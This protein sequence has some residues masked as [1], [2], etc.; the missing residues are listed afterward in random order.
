MKEDIQ[1]PKCGQTV[2]VDIPDGQA[3]V[4]KCPNCSSTMMISDDHASD[5]QNIQ[6]QINF[7]RRTPQQ[8]AKLP[9]TPP[10]RFDEAISLAS[11]RLT[12]T[13]GRSRRSEFWWWLLASAIATG[14]LLLIPH[15]GNLAFIV[16]FI[17]IYGVTIRRLNDVFAP[18]WIGTSF[19]L[20]YGML[21]PLLAVNTLADNSVRLARDLKYLIGT[22]TFSTLLEIAEILC[23]LSSIVVIIFAIKDGDPETNPLHGDSP[24]YMVN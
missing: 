7:Q 4:C 20:S 22:E 5:Q 16:Y 2:S 17:L 8:T 13:Y 1:C 9:Q 23:V 18:E 11:Q 19:L 10:L 21:T 6:P 14:F 15:W 12:E 3:L 24:K